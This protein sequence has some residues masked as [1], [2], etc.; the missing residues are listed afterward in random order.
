MKVAIVHDYL[1]EFGGAERVVAALHE[2]F[3]SAPVYT[4]FYDPQALG[5]HADRFADWDIRETWLA[6]VPLI[7]KL[8]SPL[9]FLAPKAFMDLDL[10][11]YDLVISSSNAYFAKAVKVPNGKHICYCH[12]P[13]R[14]MYG[15][16]VMGDWR[17]NPL[18]R[19]AGTFLN[20]FLRVIDVK[21]SR[22]NVDLFI[23]NSQEVAGRIKK[24]YHRESVVVHPPIEVP[25]QPK[26]VANKDRTY[27]LYA[28]RLT[29][30]KHP[31]LAVAAC[32]DLGLPLKVVGLGKMADKLKEIAGDTIEL[33][34]DV[35]DDELVDLYA[36]SKALLYPA[37]DEDFGMVPVEAMGWGTPVIAHNSGGPKETMVAGKTG[38][39]FNDLTPES[40]MTSLKK[41]QQQQF[42]PQDIYQ[43]AK[44]FDLSAFKRGI[45]AAIKQA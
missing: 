29:L 24:F 5:I 17:R 15:Y 27:Y 28:G 38:L 21:I 10:S 42:P 11:G 12:T 4:A 9:R 32:N 36:H 16:S 19:F 40:L 26:L 2:M 1:R 31:E 6:K 3:P 37:E 30:S 8:H 23:A 45:K 22:D 7:K 43:H 33:L 14:V 20:H 25:S 13:P 44:Q 34:G 39:F 35:T 18:M 41:F